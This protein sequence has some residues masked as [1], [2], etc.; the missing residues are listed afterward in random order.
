MRLPFGTTQVDPDFGKIRN[1][2]A[3]VRDIQLGLK[4]IF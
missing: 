4:C 2:R 3:D 1:T